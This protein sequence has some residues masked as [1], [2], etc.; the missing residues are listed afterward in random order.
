MDDDKSMGEKAVEF[1]RRQG[2]NDIA[3]LI[4]KLCIHRESAS[5]VSILQNEDN[6]VRPMTK[7]FSKEYCQMPNH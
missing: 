7:I 3:T 6:D 5:K 2:R 4:S 1:F